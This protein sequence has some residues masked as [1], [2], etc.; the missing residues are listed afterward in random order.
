MGR[1]APS[2]LCH[3]R[4]VFFVRPFSAESFHLLLLLFPLLQITTDKMPRRAIKREGLKRE[5]VKREE[6]DDRLAFPPFS[7]RSPSWHPGTGR[8]GQ[9]MSTPADNLLN[10]DDG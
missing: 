1:D 9:C 5:R 10:Q 6:I 4:L 2:V 8:H 7:P 3:W